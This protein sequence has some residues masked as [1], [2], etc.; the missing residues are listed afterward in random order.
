MVAL[1]SISAAVADDE[2]ERFAKW[3]KTIAAFEAADE[4]NPPKK[5]GIVFTGSSSVALWKDLDKAFPQY[6]LINRGFGGSVTREVTHFAD[7]IILKHKPQIVVHYNGD[8]DLAQG[9][10]PQQVLEDYRAFIKKVRDA[11]PE[12]RI[13]IIAIK[14]SPNRIKLKEKIQEANALLKKECETVKGMVFFDAY[15]LLNNA[16]GSPRAELY[17]DG[18]HANAEGYALW[19]KGLA[20]VLKEL[21]RP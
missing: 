8:N 16:D 3:E 5:N 21:Y 19:E 6:P 11:L 4:K 17:K 14:L 9:R 12:S 13:V 2:S 10:S 20:P 18:L 15:T 1:L 7:R